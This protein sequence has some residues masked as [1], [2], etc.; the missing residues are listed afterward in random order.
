[1]ES[2]NSVNI[3]KKKKHN[4]NAGELIQLLQNQVDNHEQKYFSIIVVERK[5]KLGKFKMT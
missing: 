1:M 5:I 3:F 2:N 4:S